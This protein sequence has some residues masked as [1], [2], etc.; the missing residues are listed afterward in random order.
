MRDPVSKTRRKGWRGG[1]VVRNLYV[2]RDSSSV[3][4]YQVR[5]LKITCNSSSRE[6]SAFFWTPWV[7]VLMCA[8]TI[9]RITQ[10]KRQQ[11]FK[12]WNKLMASEEQYLG[13]FSSLYTH[14]PTKCSHGH[15]C[16]WTH[17]H[18][19]THTLM[20]HVDM[21][22]HTKIIVSRPVRWLNGKGDCYQA[23][24]LDPELDP[25]APAVERT[26]SHQVFLWPPHT[27]H[28]TYAHMHAHIQIINKTIWIH[29][30][31]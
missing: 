29:V 18:T 25:W 9:P 16:T 20:H 22:P 30:R 27:H 24:C 11:I 19:H 31:I 2:C 12:K 1:S 5:L 8:R 21:H 26:D 4:S 7:S 14:V 28:G 15:T 13:L 3:P 17:M 6:P 23:W 10:L